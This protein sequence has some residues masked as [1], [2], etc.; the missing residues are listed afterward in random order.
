MYKYINTDISILAGIEGY[1][2]E[3]PFYDKAEDTL[4]LTDI[5]DCKVKCRMGKEVFQSQKLRDP[6]T[7]ICNHPALGIIGIS[8]GNIYSLHIDKSEKLIQLRSL[9]E[10]SFDPPIVSTARTNDV[11]IDPSGN[12]WIGVITIPPE[13]NSGAVYKLAPLGEQAY[14]VFDAWLPN[15]MVWLNS[16]LMLFTDTRKRRIEAISFSSTGKNFRRDIWWSC[17]NGVAGNP[18]GISSD[19]SSVYVALWGGSAIARVDIDNTGE[20][21]LHS[22]IS[23][24]CQY[25]SSLCFYSETEE[26]KIVITSADSSG[27]AGVYI[28]SIPI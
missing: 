8:T 19:G 5:E 2:L 10:Y 14:K 18:D 23:L 4:Y 25:P 21:K 6:I 20:G 16:E 1:L 11:S 9:F 13:Q 22:L 12:F 26:K 24:P 28:A 15:G 7:A 3:S 27:H 17:E